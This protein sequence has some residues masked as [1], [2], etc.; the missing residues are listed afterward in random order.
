M[1]T[2]EKRG[3]LLWVLD[4]TET[5]M[6]ARLLRSWILKP[7]LNPAAISRRQSAVA[8]FVKNSTVRAEF[9]ELLSGMLDLE[10]LTAKAVYGTAN[11]KDLRA[12]CLS[13]QKL[14]QIKAIISE[15]SSDSVKTIASNLDTLEDVEKLLSDAIVDDP[16]FSVR[17]GGMSLC[18]GAFLAHNSKK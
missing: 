8:D 17:E 4:K 10:R 3:S 13:I 11:A 14:P 2:K 5:A 15:L 12:I 9:G 16:P 18:I 1:R 7:L 6:G